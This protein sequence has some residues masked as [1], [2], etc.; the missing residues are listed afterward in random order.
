LQQQVEPVSV[1]N[2]MWMNTVVA[3]GT[4]IGLAIYTGADTRSV[5]NTSQPQTKVGLLDQELNKLSKVL[6]GLLVVLAF[7]LVALN[8]FHGAWFIIFFRFVLLFSSII[9][10]RYATITNDYTE[11]IVI[12][13]SV[14]FASTWIWV[15]RCTR[16]GLCVTTRLPALL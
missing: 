2:T 4:V 13:P 7:L 10:I 11:N 15:R 5:M 14:V 1:E 8:K 16:G 6:F 12:N 3:S 9:P